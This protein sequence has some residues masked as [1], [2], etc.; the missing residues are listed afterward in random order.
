M[1]V[2]FAP[3]I[4][5]LVGFAAVFLVA[6]TNAGVKIFQKIIDSLVT[7]TISVVSMFP[8]GPSLPSIPSAPTDGVAVVF[9]QTLNWLF[10]IAYLVTCVQ[11]ITAGLLAY[12]VISPLA[13]LVKLLS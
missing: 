8:A 10:P 7:F 6:Q 13:R 9:F 11:F 3:L 1:P 5:W 2:L 4:S 12:F